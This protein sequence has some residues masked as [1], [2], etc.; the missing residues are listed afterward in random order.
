M[1]DTTTTNYS[2]TKPEIG[3]PDGRDLWG[4]KLN[5]NFDI[6]DAA[7]RNVDARFGTY[8]ATPADADIFG[9]LDAGSGNPVKSLVWSDIKARIQELGLDYEEGTWTP[10]W[11]P[12]SS[13]A[14]T[15]T[16]SASDTTGY[17]TK[18][19]RMV[20]AH[21]S[22]ATTSFA[23]GSAVGGPY[24]GGLPFVASTAIPAGVYP[25]AGVGAVGYRALFSG[26]APDG[27]TVIKGLDKL[28]PQ[29]QN[30]T[31]SNGAS[32][33]AASMNTGAGTNNVII[34]S[35]AYFTDS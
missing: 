27:I 30:S 1:A 32:L 4:D 24:I 31:T 34:C 25:R 28:S 3:A 21:C 19:G 20:F 35:A 23:L 16:Y 7:L 13:G 26:Q 18:I 5:D 17:Y 10:A 12:S 14:F 6:I 29:T 15:V 2:L 22:M 11:V 33:L 9:Y 8:D